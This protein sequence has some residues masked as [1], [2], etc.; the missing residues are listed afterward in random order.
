[1]LALGI[2]W[3]AANEP[4]TVSAIL[5]SSRPR[6]AYLAHATIWKDPGVLSPDDVL[7]GPSGVFPYT[8]AEATE[9]AWRQDPEVPLHNRRRSHA[10]REVLGFR[11]R[12]RQPRGLRDGGGDAADVG[13]GVRSSS[14]ASHERAL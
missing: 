8:F 7:E 1:M 6:T 14:C 11:A 13:A 10:A 12:D 4:L 5:T 9:R 3:A 2:T